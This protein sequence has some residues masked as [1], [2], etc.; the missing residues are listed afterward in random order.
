MRGWEFTAFEALSILSVELFLA[1]AKQVAGGMLSWRPEGVRVGCWLRDTR[2]DSTAKECRASRDRAQTMRFP[3]KSS[4]PTFKGR[5]KVSR[6]VGA[7]GE[8]WVGS[9]VSSPLSGWPRRLLRYL[10]RGGAWESLCLLLA[11]RRV[12]GAGGRTLRLFPFAFGR[13]SGLLRPGIDEAGSGARRLA[14]GG[15]GGGGG[16]RRARCARPRRRWARSAG[17]E[18]GAGARPGGAA[19]SGAAGAGGGGG[20]AAAGKEEE[21]ESRSRRP[22]M[23]RPAPRPLLLALLSLG[24]CAW[25][26][27]GR[28]VPGGRGCRLEPGAPEVPGAAPGRPGSRAPGRRPGGE[29]CGADRSPVHILLG[30]RFG[31]PEPPGLTEPG[32]HVCRGSGSWPVL[33]QRSLP[34]GHREPGSP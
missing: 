1:R 3:D 29:R 24:E 32:P 27:A 25:G 2:G 11:Q 34:V 7:R 5:R 33:P 14:E 22:S 23:G 19:D 20:G 28:W 21:A 18:S 16:P 31:Y 12:G 17:G 30:P 8:G 26:A 15:R 6:G 9:G 4:R 13:R 10:E